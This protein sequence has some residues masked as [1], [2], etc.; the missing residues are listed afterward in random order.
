M[1]YS[2]CP[3]LFFHFTRFVPFKL[4][5]DEYVDSTIHTNKFVVIKDLACR[6][7]G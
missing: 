2:L 6:R 7:V 3:L 4:A 1:K 5:F